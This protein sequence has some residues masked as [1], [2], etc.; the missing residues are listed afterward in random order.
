MSCALRCS[1]LANEPSA[2]DC[3][4]AVNRDELVPAVSNADTD[5]QPTPAESGELSLDERSWRSARR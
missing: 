5:G 1:K 3:C 4:A 2:H